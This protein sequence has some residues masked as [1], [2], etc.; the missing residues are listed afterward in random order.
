MLKHIA[1]VGAAA[2]IFAA[3]LSGCSVGDLKMIEG[4]GTKTTETRPVS[5]FDSVELSGVGKL[6]VKQTGTE[7]LTIEGD[8][9]IV[10][11][12]KTTVSG[13]TLDIGLEDNTSVN[14]KTP[15]IFNVTVKDIKS[16]ALSGAG[17]IEANDLK[18]SAFDTRLSG[19]GSAT[20]GNLTADSLK[21]TLSGA[22]SFEVNG[23]VTSQ[24]V[25]ISGA[26]GYNAGDLRST[27]AKVTT[28]GAG[29]ATVWATGSLIATVSGVGSIRYYGSPSVQ[30]EKSGI[31][32]ITKAGDK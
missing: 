6:I 7:S 13:G 8:D 32:S 12:I 24:D 27:T 17:S 5:G 25:T 14:P 2:L 11:K 4:S 22:G 16:V 29:S 18:S 30:S 23:T 9:N 1:A 15:L 10:P 21:V 3:L 31:G 19:A 26:G 28:S 20:L